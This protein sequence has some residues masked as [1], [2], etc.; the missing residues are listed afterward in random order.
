MNLIDEL[1]GCAIKPIVI[2]VQEHLVFN[3]WQK[4]KDYS[5]FEDVRAVIF[6]DK[7]M[8]PIALN[9]D[10]NIKVFCLINQVF[11]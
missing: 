3:S 11:N 2:I 6:T 4:I 8:L 1:K 10:K 7:K 5:T 9:V